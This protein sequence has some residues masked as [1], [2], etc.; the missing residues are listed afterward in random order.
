MSNRSKVLLAIQFFCFAYFIFFEDLLTT[1]F[2]MLIQFFGFLLCLW[3]ISV[4]GIG[5]FNAQPEVK[6]GARLVKLGP[7]G[8]IRNPMYTGL[9]LLF[10]AIFLEK[11]RWAAFFEPSNLIGFLVFLLMFLVFALKARDE[12]KFL[13]ARFG[14]DYEDYKKDTY[15]FFP[16]LY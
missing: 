3:S 11:S 15:R 6:Q 16:Y 4:M 13:S 9:L 8:R 1:G 7:Y 12:E 14:N 2:I 5:N 10:G